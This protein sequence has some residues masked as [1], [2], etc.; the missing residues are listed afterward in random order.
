MDITKSQLSISHLKMICQLERCETVKEAAQALFITQPA[1][2]NR[3]REAE[4]RLNTSLFYR[5]GRKII[6]SNAGKRLLQS[7][8][9]ILEELARAEHDISRLT[10]GIEQVLRI[11]LPHYASFQ[12]LPKLIEGFNHQHPTIE[13]EIS[14]EAAN[15]PLHALFNH[16]VDIAMISTASADLEI[17]EKNFKTHCLNQDELVA[18]LSTQHKYANKT[19]LTAHDFIDETYV[20]NST[21]PEKDREYELFFKP[22]S[23]IPKKVLQ[24]GFNDA[25]VELVKANLGVSIFSRNQLKRLSYDSDIKLIPLGEHGLTLYWHLVYANQQLIAEPAESVIAIL[26]K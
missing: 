23:V 24:V 22:E 1:L 17:D 25:I 11:G 26:Q 4:R 9:K 5:R 7:A 19:Y 18:C 10:D 14:S 8:K 20:T 12:W 6:M 21:V 2:T 16:D 13:L 15:Q 3:I